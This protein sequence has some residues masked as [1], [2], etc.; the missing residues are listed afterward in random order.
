MIDISHTIPKEKENGFNSNDRGRS[1]RT[2]TTT[3][4]CHTTPNENKNDFN[5]NDL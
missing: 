4:I 5:L 1:K 2:L 3:H